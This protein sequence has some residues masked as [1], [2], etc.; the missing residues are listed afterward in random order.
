MVLDVT[1][2]PAPEPA[3]P[4]TTDAPA[5]APAPAAASAVPV[6][7]VA[8]LVGGALAK[9]AQDAAVAP[10]ADDGTVAADAGVPAAPAPEAQDAPA[11]VPASSAAE[12]APA[13]A[14]PV[15]ALVSGAL[16]KATAEAERA[17]EAPAGAA[18][19]GSPG[20]PEAT[21]P[22]DEKKKARKSSKKTGFFGR[23]F[24]SSSGKDKEE[25]KEEA[26]PPESTA[27]FGQSKDGFGS[28]VASGVASPEELSSPEAEKQEKAEGGD[29]KKPST[30]SGA[31][32]TAAPAMAV[33]PEGGWHP[34]PRVHRSRRDGS[35]SRGGV[36]VTRGGG[37]R[38]PRAG[39]RG[40]PAQDDRFR[41]AGVREHPG[42]A[43]G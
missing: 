41:E 30:D 18:E 10:A 26:K 36:D 20:S 1:P 13:P 16:R 8:A 28:P 2:D 5:P 38:G 37:R 39:G 25:D 23:M 14:D 35:R 11:V 32:D 22:P 19:P 7:P 17:L 24:G 15:A 9:A 43:S 3:A 6:D 31:G 34:P 42:S 27:S 29:E 21:S 33:V 4:A 12:P 40:P